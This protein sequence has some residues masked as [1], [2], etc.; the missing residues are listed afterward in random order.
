[1][2]AHKSNE[3]GILGLAKP[4]INIYNSETKVRPHAVVSP[5]FPLAA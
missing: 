4:R 1:M 5:R 2:S 3:T